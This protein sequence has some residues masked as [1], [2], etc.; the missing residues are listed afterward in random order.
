MVLISYG[1]NRETSLNQLRTDSALRQLCK[2]RRYVKPDRSI[3]HDRATRPRGMWAMKEALCTNSPGVTCS[4]LWHS[5]WL[6]S[7]WC[8]SF[9]M[10]HCG[11]QHH[12]GGLMKISRIETKFPSGKSVIFVPVNNPERRHFSMVYSDVLGSNASREH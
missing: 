9:S 7:Y 12:Q 8:G 3:S 4:S 11:R 2:P 10:T 6:R 1:G 5:F